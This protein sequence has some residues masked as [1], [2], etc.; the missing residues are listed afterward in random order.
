M[1]ATL[2]HEVLIFHPPEVSMTPI[3]IRTVVLG[4]AA[5]LAFPCPGAFADDWIPDAT[6]RLVK[7]ELSGGPT[8]YPPA[9][10]GLATYSRGARN[11]N[12]LWHTP[13]GKPVSV[14]TAATYRLTSTEYVE[15]PM[16][17]MFHDPSAGPPRYTVGGPAKTLPVKRD[18]RRLQFTPPEAPTMVFDGDGFTATIEGV[19]VDYWE[20]VR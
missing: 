16:F 13:D 6:Y 2:Q 7:R 14:S 5:G 1:A 18:G 12:V 20:K 19:L 9:V 10:M 3:S 11:I 4:I 8:L 17:N 15:T